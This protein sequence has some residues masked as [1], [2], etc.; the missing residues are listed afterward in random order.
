[1]TAPE[2]KEALEPE[3]SLLELFLKAHRM[4]C[5]SELRGSSVTEWHPCNCGSDKALAALATL[6]SDLAAALKRAESAEAE[7]QALL[8]ELLAMLNVNQAR[9]QSAAQSSAKIAQELQ[10]YLQKHNP[11]V[12]ELKK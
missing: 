3:P 5:N 2:P 8:T 1:M 9:A 4:G 10:T 6:R 11:D 7:N 12:V